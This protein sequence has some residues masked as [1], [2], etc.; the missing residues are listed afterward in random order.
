MI[1]APTYAPGTTIWV[2]LGTSDSEGAK[3]FY[4][5]LFGWEVMDLGPEAGGY[6]FFM[7]D[8][9]M[10]GGI[11]P[12]QNPAQPPAWSTYFSTADADATAAA[13]RDAGGQVIFEPMDVMETGR[14]AIFADAGGAVFGVWQPKQHTGMGVTNQPG[15][16]CWTELATRDIAGA[17]QF[18][19][20]VF[21]WDAGGNGYVEWKL[22]DKH[23]GGGMAMG[24]NY[25]PHI[26]PHWLIYFASDTIEQTVARAQELGGKA[27]MPV[28]EIGG[29]M[30]RFAVIQDPQGAVFGVHED[31]R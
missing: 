3:A 29:G 7:R 10:V 20:S 26:P 1:E 30:G 19:R 4:G 2:D 21:G 22:G 31:A 28:T 23:V 13:V 8:G 17:K 18:Y 14:M 11:G 16:Y 9:K 27:L 25:P 24:E 6:A 15:S 5:G 12:L